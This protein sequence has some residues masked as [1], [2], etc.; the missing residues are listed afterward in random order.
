M[1][2]APDT[3]PDRRAA[4]REL[5]SQVARLDLADPVVLAL[6]RGGVP[7]AAEIA[8]ALDAPLDVL[9]VRKIGA[10]G[11]RELGLGA[12]GEGGVTVLD[13][14]LVARLRADPREVE[15]TAAAERIELERRAATYRGRRPPIEVRDRDAVIVDDG[16]ATGGSAVAAVE[17]V[18]RRGAR[19]VVVAV[20]VA[21]ESGAGRLRDAADELVCPFTASGGFAVGAWYDDFHQLDD[22]EVVDLLSKHGGGDRDERG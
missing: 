12:V 21:A 15:R 14:A 3:Y 8:M 9:L 16:I 13:T 11:H 22:D 4:G 1:R 20:P 2:R 6:P 5:A 19:T 10:P 18:R 17:V 7:V